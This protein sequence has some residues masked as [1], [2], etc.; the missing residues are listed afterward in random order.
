[1]PWFSTVYSA[2]A[3]DI[4]RRLWGAVSMGLRQSL[5]APCLIGLAYLTG[6]PEHLWYSA[7]TLFLGIPYLLGGYACKAYPIGFAEYLTGGLLGLLF[8]ATAS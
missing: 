4:R 7:G 8:Y 2:N 6:H 1:M 3:S 5:A